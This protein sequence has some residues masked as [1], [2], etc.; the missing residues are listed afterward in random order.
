MWGKNEMWIIAIRIFLFLLL[1]GLLYLR[2]ITYKNSE[3]LS[4]LLDFLI[5]VALFFIIYLFTG[6]WIF[7]ILL[8]INI[9]LL[10]KSEKVTILDTLIIFSIYIVYYF[11]GSLFNTDMLNAITPNGDGIQINSLGV[12]LLVGTFLLIKYVIKKL[13]ITDTF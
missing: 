7:F 5:C 3:K 8:L 1:F 9:L 4:Y 6:G 12:L 11:I 2:F 13:R 10:V